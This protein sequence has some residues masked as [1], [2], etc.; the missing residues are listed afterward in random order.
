MS[1]GQLTHEQ[2]TDFRAQGFVIARGLADVQL[3]ARILA[4]ARADLTAEVAPIE[5]EAQLHYPGAPPSLDAPGG[6]TAR[7]LL[8][9][10]GRD[11]VL[12]GWGTASSV[13][14]RVEQLLGAHVALCQAH[15]NCVMSS[16]RAT[17][18]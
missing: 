17:A 14:T 13:A 11:P 8:Q 4:V 6:H 7:R 12:R 3:C 18:R 9:A 10:C 1:G 16:S 2:L 15:H 5:Y